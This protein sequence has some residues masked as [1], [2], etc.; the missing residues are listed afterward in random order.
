[1]G[2]DA[3][4]HAASPYATTAKARRGIRTYGDDR[5][6]SA[7]GWGATRGGDSGFFVNKARDNIASQQPLKRM[8]KRSEHNEATARLDGR[9]GD[10]G[11]ETGGTV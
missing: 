3:T 6:S 10:K 4:T 5:G 8:G 2:S 7:G 9:D 11:P 1:M